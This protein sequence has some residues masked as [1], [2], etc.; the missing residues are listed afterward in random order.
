MKQDLSCLG[1]RN[2]AVKVNFAEASITGYHFCI[3]CQ[4]VTKKV[5]RGV[6]FVCVR[7]GSS[8]VKFYPPLAV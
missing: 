8:R 2:F 5:Q 3:A 4:H 7:C 6:N 1:D